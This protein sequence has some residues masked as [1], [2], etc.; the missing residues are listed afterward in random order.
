[1]N[2]ADD[3]LIISANEH[4]ARRLPGPDVE[5]GCVFGSRNVPVYDRLRALLADV[6]NFVGELDTFK[7][8]PQR[9]TVTPG[10][11]HAHGHARGRNLQN[12]STDLWA[13]NA[14]QE[15]QRRWRSRK[16]SST[17]AVAAI[18]S[19]SA[20]AAQARPV[21][22]G[23]AVRLVGGLHVRRYAAPPP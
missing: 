11:R 17:K 14:D 22:F 7:P 13:V 1:V 6:R 8:G 19:G 5:D 4:R 20:C 18:E 21:A 10:P 16:A 9:L 15:Y 3:E 23:L 12:E 2:M